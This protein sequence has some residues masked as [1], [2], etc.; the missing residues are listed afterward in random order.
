MAAN[1]PP[2]SAPNL[3]AKAG[4]AAAIA[5]AVAVA[6]PLAMKWEGYAAKPY[7]DPAKIKTGCFGETEDPAYLEDRIYSRS[8]CGAQLRK[9]LAQDYAPRIAACLPEIV[10]NRFVFGALLDAS[11]NAGPLAV[12]RSRMA[13]SI[14]AGNLEAGCKGL[15]GWYVTARNRQTGVRVKLRGLVNR[16]RDEMRACLAGVSA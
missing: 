16:R 5:A 14:R 10:S 15:D 13:E 2:P 6:A 7:L 3:G 12:C 4:L 11:Y 1:S 8:E 9:R